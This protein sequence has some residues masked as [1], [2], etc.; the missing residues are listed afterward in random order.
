MSL[1]YNTELD[2]MISQD[3][4]KDGISSNHNHICGHVSPAVLQT[5]REN[6]ELLMGESRLNR[7]APL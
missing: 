3:D 1:F 4:Y 7:K 2:M 5:R 6:D